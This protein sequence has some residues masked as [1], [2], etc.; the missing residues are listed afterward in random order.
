[1]NSRTS[2]A[3]TTLRRPWC[4]WPVRSIGTTRSFGSPRASRG[5]SRNRPAT[6]RCCGLAPR[7][8][9]TRPSCGAQQS[10]LRA[11]RRGSPQRWASWDARNCANA[12]TRSWIQRG[13]A[14]RSRARR[15]SESGWWLPAWR[16][17]LPRRFRKARLI[18]WIRCP[19]RR[20][21]PTKRRSTRTERSWQTKR[22]RRKNRWRWTSRLRSRS[23][24][25]SHWRWKSRSSSKSQLNY[26][27]CRM[28]PR[29]R[30]RRPRCRLCLLYRPCH[31]FRPDTADT[32][33]TPN[34]AYTPNA[35]R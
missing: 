16:S 30:N 23:P 31:R 12:S 5:N 25:K 20:A 8:P 6:M 7:P 10:A 11:G 33:R 24:L 27:R 13:R 4:A 22:W 34:S 2:G 17:S 21:W 3:T 18:P 9:T 32:A 15:R 29:H 14:L 26:L 28:R 35:S 19:C 1:M